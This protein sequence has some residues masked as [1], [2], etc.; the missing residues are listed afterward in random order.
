MNKCCK[1]N[2]EFEGAF[3]PQC[4]TKCEAEKVCPEC[5][6][7]V[8]GSVKFCNY[9]GYDFSGGNSAAEEAVRSETA[10]IRSTADS[11]PRLRE[12]FHEWSVLAKI[13]PN[14]PIFALMLF[15]LLTWVFCVAPF[16]SFFGESLGNTYSTINGLSDDYLPIAY[17]ALAFCVLSFA[18][19]ATAAVLFFLPSTSNVKVGKIKLSSLM[20]Y[21]GNVFY[22]SFFALGCAV[23]AKS[24]EIGAE[25]G[26][27][28]GVVIAFAAVFALLSV[29]SIAADLLLRRYGISYAQ[30]AQ[31]IERERNECE[32]LCRRYQLGTNVRAQSK[33]ILAEANISEPTAVD[34]PNKRLR[35]KLERFNGG[36]FRVAYVF[37]FI[38]F[39]IGIVA[40]I[41]VCVYDKSD[42]EL[43]KA[44]LGLVLGVLFVITAVFAVCSYTKQKLYRISRKKGLIQNDFELLDRDTALKRIK[45]NKIQLIIC[46]VLTILMIIVIIVQEVSFRARFPVGDIADIDVDVLT[47]ASIELFSVFILL[48]IVFIFF[49]LL[50]FSYMRGRKISRIFGLNGKNQPQYGVITCDGEI[51]LTIELFSRQIYDY[52]MY[53]REMRYYNYNLRLAGSGKPIVVRPQYNWH[54]KKIKALAVLCAVAVAALSIAV[55]IIVDS[56]NIFKQSKVNQIH[57]GMTKDEVVKV[58]GK[59]E[60]ASDY[61]WNYYSAN[62]VKLMREAEDLN[63]QM[64]NATSLEQAFA[65]QKKIDELDKKMKDTTF[66]YITVSF[67]SDGK[68][69]NVEYDFNFKINGDKSRSR[70]PLFIN[71]WHS[72]CSRLTTDT[73]T[74][75][76]A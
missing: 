28:A 62:Y 6:A 53:C 73:A 7:V 39:V 65:I 54:I 60:F 49:A 9:C 2:A 75:W 58:L 8:L 27:F 46:G 4:G 13:L 64:A 34:V 1:C 42:S 21:V 32:K 5:K 40:T 50:S 29:G 19:S 24:N 63:K 52:D 61:S 67:D 11:K 55:G 74:Q 25:K 23:I 59:A 71:C 41:V 30:A 47:K 44:M 48:S 12:L 57:Q 33:Q 76:L 22:I 72:P 10:A 66:K 51:P 68:V 38:V 3:C 45:N 20:G 31:D 35:R 37:S 14:V 36:I 26:A 56:Q 43:L 15:S 69:I 16:A 70:V 17:A 18:Y